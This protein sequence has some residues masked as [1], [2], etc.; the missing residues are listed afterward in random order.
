MLTDKFKDSF[1]KFT[2]GRVRL[3][4]LFCL[5]FPAAAAIAV[6][7][8]P[9]AVQ[10]TAVST[11]SADVSWVLD[12]PGTEAPIVLL[13]SNNFSTVLSSGTMAI[14]S[15]T[16]T[17]L[18]LGGNTT[19]YFKVKVS[20]ENDAAYSSVITTVT[21]VETPTGIFFEETTTGTITASA[22]TAT[23]GF[24][25]LEV[26]LSGVNVYGNG[27]YAGWRN[28][29]I[30]TTK[31]VMTTA[32]QFP[33]AAAVGGKV[34]VVGGY[35]GGSYLNA[36]EEYDPA[37]NTWATKAVMPTGRSYFAAAAVGGKLY[38]VGGSTATVSYLNTNEEYDP[39]ANTWSAKA[40]MPTAR[41]YFTAASI[42]GKLYAVGGSASGITYLNANEEYDPATN[43]WSAK[44]VM[45]TAR[46]ALAAAAV[47]G[48]LYAVGGFNVSYQNRNDEYDPVADTWTTRA[49]M[50]TPR[51]Y[52]AAAAVGG[53]LYAVGGYN[54]AVLNMNEEYDPAANMWST[55]AAII[56]ARY[57]LA[58]VGVGGK[59]YA[60]GGY[61]GSSSLNTNEAYDPGVA[62]KFT[63]LTPNTQYSFK[64]KARD[65]NGTETS[66]SATVSTYTLAYAAGPAAFPAVYSSSITVAWSSGTV[67]GGYNGPGA[68]YFVQASNLPNFNIIAGSSQTLNLFATVEGLTPPTTF[69][70]RVKAANSLN[71]W[72]D[73]VVIGSTVNGVS[74]PV[75]PVVSGVYLSSIAVSYA[76]VAGTNGYVVDASTLSDFSGMI[77]SSSTSD[78]LLS[79]LYPQNLIPN[80][81]FY[82]RAGSIL[83]QTTAYANTVPFS[84]N[85]LIA[86]PADIVFDEITAGTITASAYSPMPGFTNVEVGLS[87]VNVSRDGAY[88][89]WRTGNVWTTKAAMPAA[90]VYT[91]VA[92]VGGKLYVV[93][94]YVPAIVNTNYEYDPAANTWATKAAMPSVRLGAGAAVAGGKLYVVA[95]SSL[96]SG[97]GS[98]N[99][100]INQAYD[101]ATNTWAT[102]AALP[103]GRY[104]PTAAAVGGKIYVMGGFGSGGAN[105]DTNEEYDPLADS[106]ET[107]TVMP[108]A[109]NALSA[110]VV[111]DKIYAVGGTNGAYV[112]VNE[113]YD[114]AL[115]TWS[116]KAAMPTARGY[117][118]A[119]TLGGKIYAVGGSSAAVSYLNRNEEY[120]PA[121][122]AWVTKAAM[123]TGRYVTG[124]AVGGKLYAVGGWTGT[125]QNKNEEYDPGVAVKFAGLTPN[126]QYFFKAKARNMNGTE[127]LESITV[128]TYTL[129]YAAGPVSFP[130]V[131]S[132][133]ITV[134]WS[135]GT[136]SV[137][138]NGPGA[139]YLVQASNLANFNTIAGSSQTLNPFATVEGLAPPTTFYFRVKAANNLG[140]W[141]YYAVLG[142]TANGTS[143]PVNPVVSAVYSS[144]V[145]V[146]Y[147]PVAGTNGYIV[148]ASTA[149]NFSGTLYSSSTSDNLLSVLSPQNLIPN[150]TFYLR[151]GSILGQTTAYAYTVPFSTN[152]LLGTPTN[153]VFD[154]IT[155][156]TIT[157]SAYAAT[158]G[159]ISLEQ[160][161]SGVNVARD[162]VYAGWRNGNSWTTK[163]VMTTA[164]SRLAAAVVGGKIYAVGGTGAPTNTNEEYDP[165]AN[166]WTTKA[167][168]PTGR[169]DLVAVALSGKIYALGGYSDMNTNE[170]YDPTA[171]TWAAKAPM[172]TARYSFGAAA[173]GGKIY[174][175]GGVGGTQ[176]EN[177]EY[178]PASNTWSTKAVMPTA[179]RYL[180]AAALNGKIYAVGGY[181]GLIQDTNEEYDPTANT[182]AAKAVMPT[183][184]YNLAAAVVGAK[185]YA[186]GGGTATASYFNANE[187]Y[188]PASN[189][190]A[191]KAVMPTA[192]KYFVT[193]AMGGKLY[194][195]GGTNGGVLATNEEY[196]PGV[197]AKFSGLIP[198]TQYSFKAKARAMNGIETSESITV[199]T[200]TLAVASVSVSGT[201]FLQ[202]DWNR[203]RVQW[204]S[205]T[206]A[207]GFNAPGA[208]YD[209]QASTGADFI[210]VYGSSNTASLYA[211]ITL[212]NEMT[213]YYFRVRGVN[214]IGV[215]DDYNILGSTQTPI[216]SPVNVQWVY[217]SSTQARVSWELEATAAESPLIVISTVADFSATISSVTGS[218]GQ[219]ATTYALLDNTSYYFKVKVSTDPDLNYCPVI[220][221]HTPAP[222][223]SGIVFDEITAGTITA[224]AY[225]PTPGFTS[226]EVGSSGVNVARDGAYAGWRSANS[227]STKAAMPTARYGLSAAAVGGK[228]YAVGGNNVSNL[229]TNEE[230]DPAANT[231]S[232]KAAMPAVRRELASA[233]VGG[234]LYALGG[235][236]GADLNTN[237]EYD[238][239]ANTW[240]AKAAMP[241]A[242]YGLSA[243]ALGGKL[244][245]VG[246]YNGSN[247]NTNEEYDPAANTWSTKAAMPA[248]RYSLSAAA[249]GGKLYALGGYSGGDKNTNYEYD[250]VM[251]TWVTK[252]VIPT[253]QANFAAAVL[254]GKLYAVGGYNGGYR[255]TNYEY[256]PANNTWVTKVVMPTAR[257]HLA[258]ASVGGKLFILGGSSGG[259]LNTNE[260]YDPG[261]AVKFTGLIPNTQ[262]SFKAKARD[263]NGIETSESVTVSTYTLAAATVSLSGATFL[264]N[265]WNR[266]R[267]QWSSGTNAGGF[268]ASGARYDLQASTGADFIPVYGSSNTANLSADIPLLSAL[269]TYYFRVRGVNSIG[270]QGDYAVLGSTKTPVRSPVNVQWVYVS[271]TQARVS[272]ELEAPA[273]ESPFIAISTVANF[274]VTVSS[275]AGSLGQQTTAYALLDNTS[276]YFKVKVSTD[277]D[278]NYCPVIS[279]HTP[280]PI[281]SGIVFDEITPGTITASAYAAT[282]GFTNMEVGSSGVNVARNGAYAGWRNGNIWTAKAAM[283][284][285][286]Q[287]PAAAAI[288]GK[289]YAVGGLNGVYL[290]AN[291]EY[292]PVANAWLV[293]ADMPTARAYFAAAPAGGRLYALGGNNGAILSTNEEYDPVSNAW[294]TKADMPTARKDLA[295]ASAE[296]R[297]Y[298]VGGNN[299]SYLNI[300]E[301]YD[302]ATNTWET[303]AA[304]SV[305]RSSLSAA[306]IGGKMYFVGGY[307]GAYQNKN[308][309]YDPVLNTWTTKAAMPVARY[310]LA[311]AT[312]GGK[313]YA[314]GGYTGAYQNKN[315]EYDPAANT[316]AEKA[317]MLS[318]RQGLA[319]APLGGKVYLVGGNSGGNLNTN[320]EYDPG[321][322][323]KFT[324]LIP[325]TQYSFKA[326]ARDMNGTETSESITVSTYTLAYAAGPASYPAVYSSSITVTWSSGTVSGGYNGPGAVYL[327]QASN[328][329]NFNTIA[330]SSQ[331]LNPFA[332]VE[333][334]T[335]PTTF[336]FRVKALNSINTWSDYFVLGSTAN[337]VSVPANP[338]V[339]AVYP[340]SISVSYGPAAGINGYVVDASTASD[341]SGTLY[342]SSTSDTLLFVLS[343]QNLIPNTT[344]YLRA[345][346][347]LGQSTAYTNT[348]PFSTSTLIATPTGIVFDEITAGTITASAYAATPGFS[349]LEVG[350]SGVNV[351][352]NGSYAG[353][354]N[355]NIWTTKT[356]L[357]A[358]RT[359]P[360]AAAVGGRLFVVG[361]FSGVLQNTNYEYDS[362]ANSW[363]TKTAMPTA[364][365]YSCAVA[366]GG[367]LYI[368]G[369]SSVVGSNYIATNEEYDPVANSWL[370]KADMPTAR[371][372]FGAAGVGGKV[373]VVGGDNGISLNANEEYDPATNTWA[374]K[375]AMPT[376]RNQ[377]G[378]AAFGG[379]IYAIGGVGGLN[380][381]EEYDPAANAWSAKAAMPTARNSVSAA[382]VGGKIYALVGSGSAT[383]MN[384]NEEYDPAADT[385]ATKAVVPTA[386][387]RVA[388]AAIGGKIHVMGGYTPV[389]LNVNEMYDPGAAVKFTGLTPNTQYSFKAKARSANGTETPES[390]LVSTYTLAA[391]A[392]SVSG[393]TFLQSDWNRVS[394]QWSSGTNAGGFNAPGARYDLQAS[395]GSDFIPVAGSS[396]TANLSADIAGLSA[397][398]TYYLRVRGVNPL[399]VPAD[400]TVLGSTLTPVKSPANVSPADGATGVSQCPSLQAVLEGNTTAQ[401]HFQL[402]SF[403]TMDSQGG[404]PLYSF[405]QTISQA[406]TQ[407][408][409]A[410]Q[411]A[412][413]SVSSDAYLAVSTA[414][415]TFYSGTQAVTVPL[416]AN[417]R[418][419]FRARAKSSGGVFSVWSS[420][421]SFTTGEFAGAA[422]INNAAITNISVSRPAD[423][424][425]IA[426]SFTIRENNISTGTTDNN[427]NWNT[428]DWVFVKFS[429]AAGADG[430][431]NHAVMG[432][433]GG[434]GAGAGLT[435]ATDNKGVFLDHTAIQSLWTSTATLIWNYAANGVSGYDLGQTVF[436]VFSIAMVRIPQGSYVYNVSNLGGATFNNPAGNT[437]VN[438]ASVIP[439]GAA[440]G[441]PNGYNSFY[442]MRYEISQGQ[443]AGFLN[444]LPSASATALHYVTVANGHNMTY[445]G[446]NPYGSQYAAADPNAAK[447][448]LSTADAWSFLSWAALRPMTEMEFEKA[449]R[450]LSPD[451]RVY[452]WG[453]GAPTT[454]LYAP[455]NEAGTH[456]LNY[457][458]YNNITDGSKVLDVGR[459]MSGDVYRTL[460]QT[461]ASPYGIADLAGNLS[462][463]VLNCSFTSVPS[464]GNGIV[465]WPD[466]WP[467]V[468]ST[469]KGV[470]GG[471]WSNDETRVRVSDRTN[472]SYSATFRYS[473]IGA[474]GVRA[475]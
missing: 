287:Y 40:A 203:V 259:L 11:N 126:T 295:A 232:T 319:A 188:D 205:G 219:Q 28:G 144:S 429:T 194:A 73:Y 471:N 274:S 266:V 326:K 288:G 204:S 159:F 343:P 35:F 209:L 164:R 252:A 52:L 17:Y 405:D 367:K 61:N 72:G 138:Y 24:S 71:I 68:A 257:R 235:T 470:R 148:H 178:D 168:M 42:G 213:T 65:I 366:A 58:A 154:E 119:A 4:V 130:A 99:L 83:G 141:S 21:Y 355:G 345:G 200:Y 129:A 329:A 133:S 426:I 264:Q 76:P 369:G 111:G 447:N 182:W 41:N 301:E 181:T 300:N 320:E 430:T 212:L 121:T 450:D 316:W 234:K 146:S 341:F 63:G 239:T 5:F 79:V 351:Y 190:W 261:V 80:T 409:F 60:V 321:V 106:W 427:A 81:T 227:W 163:M 94:G 337:G 150:T 30:W 381:N 201:T 463:G 298:A 393:V 265:D 371:R 395:T 270:S 276:Y 403:A 3:A 62:A 251:N 338:V 53:K 453:S 86:I 314:V 51:R 161:L 376:A 145:S 307:N 302:P 282:P 281:P 197:A 396:N 123:P 241:T 153:I 185:L 115:N 359:D 448:Y 380:T 102:K 334:L 187:E 421:W 166:T 443:Y 425:T 311:A 91:A 423:P 441:W 191:T 139:G 323:A 140:V 57:S 467:A 445:T 244:Y 454:T 33:S 306:T 107:K 228:L 292:D 284:T 253:A 31:T 354:R 136:V 97:Y 238:P 428:A 317:A 151:A 451:A 434:V 379:K 347:L 49:V 84:T 438:S 131:Y 37:A 220:S 196:D 339:V 267:V 475:P 16:T 436:K 67:S 46:N 400:Y 303:K 174:A 413:V 10:F 442:V 352:G 56:T 96:T 109:R 38:A 189:T 420:T 336:Y 170:E 48:K 132:S 39:V 157:A 218:L 50:P 233:V 250:P 122:N 77:Y 171:N 177:E 280:A 225:A 13:S 217:V 385:W 20:T 388:A 135:S 6:A 255:N 192:R 120:D 125:Y 391:A 44:A 325:N 364:R 432:A 207:G 26:G 440:A 25:N 88:A 342:S 340:S 226:L 465:V 461:G 45:L 322:A 23:P 184:R 110:A 460:S 173:A 386:R 206:N 216:R 134:A 70:F 286:R 358:T 167:V 296:G 377:L 407:G 305:L 290:S 100:A 199:S 229:N 269:T 89:G 172:P 468:D 357:P 309:E 8:T 82:L 183:A 293:K 105:L 93:G 437:L 165:A 214:S 362:V 175:V 464:N 54:G 116:A 22:Y 55:K 92:T 414:A 332:T 147:G 108:T 202:N 324:G 384:T 474:R 372:F 387:R 349:N 401:Y 383:N 459:Y 449:S 1:W 74:S 208:R 195:L 328:L 114:P 458:N 473:Y 404:S 417:T 382:S 389:I 222:I 418:Y 224:S 361:G 262:Y 162:G 394:V 408:V 294:E 297:L 277:L 127:T 7:A 112:N 392:A 223:P 32:R 78:N 34:Y 327:V 353:W 356:G 331:T 348:V 457:L 124:A 36:N 240:S 271:S 66:E 245:A 87:G 169:Y 363:A 256:D 410:G 231:W 158:P 462:D 95:G 43:I 247:L 155:A 149:S 117:F 433:G 85:T 90:P 312:V 254:G 160:G 103:T 12:T 313:L 236:N 455:A 315:H 375:A 176:Q 415:F 242:R 472:A 211:D 249:L 285:V 18:A 215:P 360:A 278:I 431:W 469:A 402:D 406:F 59:V 397:V 304:M 310:S 344:F 64:A 370:A 75:N 333:G 47:G 221:T 258:A 399:G 15:Q 198:N 466:D 439:A 374:T 27:T 411:N 272:W 456:A 152:T 14:G 291:E 299:G 446:G 19:Y 422:P 143:V 69:Y 419:Y 398:T 378:A 424:E 29:N 289:L 368:V 142:S 230:Y 279:T 237:E 186:V 98:T 346:S 330:G 283:P 452:P 390:V 412:V 210:P 308:E 179:R 128:S 193:V 275:A 104:Y 365:A 243:A 9:T 263:M 444:T 268:N 335:P 248:V 113:E 246:G 118:A 416:S 156:G 137:G 373:Y 2:A 350:L 101:P 435:L 273:A 318:A 260:E 180:T